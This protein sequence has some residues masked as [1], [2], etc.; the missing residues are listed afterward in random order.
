MFIEVGE[1][2]HVMYRSL[3]EKS[4]RRHFIGKVTAVKDALCRLEGYVFIYDDK[5]TEFIKKPEIR[6]TI[7]DL[8]ESGYIVNAI[9]PEVMLDEICYKYAQEVGLIATDMKGF[10]LNVNEF[11]SKS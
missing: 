9:V 11:G 7:I 10:V 8:A 4:T 5:K 2:F 1:K 3:Y 6:T